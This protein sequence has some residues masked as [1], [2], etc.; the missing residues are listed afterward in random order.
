MVENVGYNVPVRPAW[1][2]ANHITTIHR[3]RWVLLSPHPSPV[4]LRLGTPL[5]PLI[6]F[7]QTKSSSGHLG[8]LL[9][10]HS[11]DDKLPPH[12]CIEILCIYKLLIKL[13]NL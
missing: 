8:H 10:P 7:L 6:P 11:F 5:L 4:V 13:K 2:A 1:L 12:K 9:N 3:S